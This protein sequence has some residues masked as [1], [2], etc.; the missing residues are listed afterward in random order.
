MVYMNWSTDASQL[1]PDHTSRILEFIYQ[2]LCQR[3]KESVY[4]EAVM[5]YLYF[6]SSRFTLGLC[7]HIFTPSFCGGVFSFLKDTR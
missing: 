7:L 3:N 5:L 6:S 1:K 2:V 4:A